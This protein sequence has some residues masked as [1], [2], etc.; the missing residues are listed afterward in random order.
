MIVRDIKREHLEAYEARRSETVKPGTVDQEIGAAKAV[1]NLAFENDL[2]SE[3]IMGH[4]DGNS[5][6]KRYDDVSDRDKL[7]AVNK[8][9]TYRNDFSKVLA[10]PLVLG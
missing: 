9:E 10:K 3:A 7:D 1:I 6:S 4:S 8:L 5:M 2:V